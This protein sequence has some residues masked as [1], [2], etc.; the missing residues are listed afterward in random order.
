VTI[1]T[2][3]A[4]E[5]R[6]G[7]FDCLAGAQDKI[8]QGGCGFIDGLDLLGNQQAPLFIV[9]LEHGQGEVFGAVG[10]R[11]AIFHETFAGH[12]ELGK[13]SQNLTFDRADQA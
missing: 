3:L 4:G 6:V 7:P 12:D 2:A 1:P 8:D 10:R 13:L 5:V 11:R 9:F